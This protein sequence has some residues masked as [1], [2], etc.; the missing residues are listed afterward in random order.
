VN[1]ASITPDT[2]TDIEVYCATNVTGTTITASA[3]PLIVP[4][5]VTD[6]GTATHVT[7][8]IGT[9]TPDLTNVD[10]ITFTIYVDGVAK[11]TF[12]AN[13]GVAGLYDSYTGSEAISEALTQ[14]KTVQIYGQVTSQV[15]ALDTIKVMSWTVRN[16]IK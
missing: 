14:D 5:G 6:T 15:L 12:T 13:G 11:D 16:V 1:P 7:V 2:D 8:Y 3:T 10:T 4:L 9:W